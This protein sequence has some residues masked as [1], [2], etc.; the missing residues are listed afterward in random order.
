MRS[1][2][3]VI[4][5]MLIVLTPESVEAGFF[6]DLRELQ[7][8]VKNKNSGSGGDFF[9][10]IQ[11]NRQK[12]VK[13]AVK[14]QISNSKPKSQQKGA[15][16][17]IF[18]VQKTYR[19]YSKLYQPVAALQLAGKNQEA[20][21][22]YRNLVLIPQKK[23]AVDKQNSGSVKVEKFKDENN[24]FLNL[25]ELASLEIDAGNGK[26]AAKHLTAARLELARQLD[27]SVVGSGVSSAFAFGVETLV[28]D[29]ELST[30]SG[31]GLERVLMLNLYSLAYLLE[32]DRKAYNAALRSMTVQK[33]EERAFI[34]QLDKIRRENRSKEQEIESVGVDNSDIQDQISKE[35]DK[36]K[37][38]AKRVENAYAIPFG[39]YLAGV[40]KEF[41]SYRGGRQDSVLLHQAVVLYQ[42]ALDIAKL[43]HM[44][45]KELAKLLRN[46]KKNSRGSGEEIRDKKILHVLIGDGVVPEKK[47][48]SL[49]VPVKQTVIPLQ[50]PLYEPIDNKTKRVALHIKQNGKWQQMPLNSIADIEANFMRYQEDRKPYLFARVLLAFGRTILEKRALEKAGTFGSIIGQVR[51][52]MTH[53]DT[54][55]WRSVP[56][57]F[58]ASRYELDPKH[59]K[60]Q[61]RLI[62]YG[63]GDKRLGHKDFWVDAASHNFVYIRS[64]QNAVTVHNSK[65]LWINR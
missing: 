38:V 11:Q 42:R 3:L 61:L 57:S 62:S 20:Q 44:P 48:L 17:A 6:D 33:H 50:I 46:L 52:S 34:K 22:V 45:H 13:P 29:E 63:K 54:R 30:Y 19:G 27:S 47:I 56:A 23:S 12:P 43:N 21:K 4:F 8:A 60:T 31:E 53:P 15:A 49:N 37:S 35:Y 14:K 2:A 1:F 28:G 39:W 25:V 5:A 41:D 16:A 24:S 18:G 55:S 9:R 59:G 32:G 26:E 58:E 65:K 40:I 64:M 36:Y 7:E 10:K 51:D